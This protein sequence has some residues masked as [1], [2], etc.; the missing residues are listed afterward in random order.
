MSTMI[1]GL[2]FTGEI[3]AEDREILTEGACA[4]LALLV[5]KFADAP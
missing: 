5:D 2:E 3:K 4:Y 1:G